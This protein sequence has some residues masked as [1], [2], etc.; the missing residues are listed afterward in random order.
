MTGNN[1]NISS[2]NAQSLDSTIGKVYFRFKGMVEQAREKVP[3]GN[4]VNLIKR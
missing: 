2:I 3:L 4:G 1:S